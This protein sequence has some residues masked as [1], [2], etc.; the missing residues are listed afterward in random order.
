VAVRDPA[1]AGD[2]LEA[3]D[4]LG[5]RV[6]VRDLAGVAGECPDLL[7][8]TVPAGAAD[9]YAERIIATAESPSAVFDVVYAPWP[10]RLA[11]AASAAGA[12]VIGGFPML[13]HQA[14]LQVELMTGE[15]A[16]VEAMRAAGEA[17]LA[18]R[19]ASLWWTP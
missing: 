12:R 4:R 15:H 6:R 9:F 11:S 2:L 16:P 3:A 10:T 7:I 8:S 14:A 17:E 5:V 19:S 18:R 1:R 13:L